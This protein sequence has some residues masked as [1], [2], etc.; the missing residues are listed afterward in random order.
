MKDIKVIAKFKTNEGNP[1]SFTPALTIEQLTQE[2]AK[3]IPVDKVY[4][5]SGHGQDYSLRELGEI[6]LDIKLV[7][8]LPTPVPSPSPDEIIELDLSP[9]DSD[10]EVESP[11]VLSEEEQEEENVPAGTFRVKGITSPPESE[12]EKYS[13]FGNVSKK[14]SKLVSK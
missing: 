2:L 13:F 10:E 9:G 11:I 5:L 8:H 12:R 4:V 14:I 1:L 7:D 6:I 3:R